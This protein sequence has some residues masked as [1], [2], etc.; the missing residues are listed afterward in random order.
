[1][2]QILEYFIFDTQEYM[3]IHSERVLYLVKYWILKW[4]DT[5]KPHSFE[6]WFRRFRVNE[7]DDSDKD[8]SYTYNHNCLQT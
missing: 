5:L 4:V 7:I 3:F 2:K 1:M 8:G 6:S